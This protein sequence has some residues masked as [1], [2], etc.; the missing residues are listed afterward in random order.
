ML[1][2][3]WTQGHLDELNKV[4]PEV[5]DNAEPN[6][7]LLNS[8]KRTVVNYVRQQLRFSSHKVQHD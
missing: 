7:L 8:G 6:E 2:V 1:N 5:I 3:K 4:F